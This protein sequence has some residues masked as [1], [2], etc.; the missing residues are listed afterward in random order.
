MCKFLRN[1]ILFILILI[2]PFCLLEYM[3]RKMYGVNK[4]SHDI[5]SLKD[6]SEEI[7]LLILGTSHTAMALNPEFIKC[8]SFNLARGAQ[9]H[10]YDYML[11]EKFLPLLKRLKVVTVGL[12]PY[13]FG[14]DQEK[15]GAHNVKAY[16]RAAGILPRSKS[17][18]K[19]LLSYSAF[20][21]HKDDFIKD[22]RADRKPGPGVLIDSFSVPKPYPKDGGGRTTNGYYFAFGT[23]DPE[24]LSV[25]GGKRAHKYMGKYNKDIQSQNRNYLFSIIETCLA[26]NIEIIFMVPPFTDYYLNGYQENNFLEEFYKNCEEIIQ[27]Y[28][29]LRFVDYGRSGSF[30]YSDFYNSDHLNF[31]GSRKF[32]H[33]L[34]ELTR[35]VCD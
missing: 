7:E 18:K 32:S 33:I 26:K 12:Y 34:S 2:S 4:Y 9:D 3:A 31:Y 1:S 13:S 8:R 11:L 14:Y 19:L 30:Q 20:W 24:V 25:E 28:P 17:Y 35:P 6:Q 10:Y 29:K 5:Q 27:K 16:Y 23:K 15:D 22:F 21:L